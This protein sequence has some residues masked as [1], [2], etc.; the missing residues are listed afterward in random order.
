MPLEH[1]D[2][3]V[4]IIGAAIGSGSFATEGRRQVTRIITE[5]RQGTL[6]PKRVIV[7]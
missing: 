7:S 1:E 5:P 4:R 6:E 2:I 3:T